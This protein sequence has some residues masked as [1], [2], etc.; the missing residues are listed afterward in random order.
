M[1]NNQPVMKQKQ[2]KQL[3][4]LIGWGIFLI[5]SI[6][7]VLTIEP[8]ASFWDCPEFI[9]SCNKLEVGHPPGAPFFMLTG[10]FFSLFAKDPSQVAYM[11][12]LM[13][14]L[15]SA[16][17][18][19]FLF[20]SITHLAQK[21][22]CPNLNELTVRQAV[23]IFGSGTVGALAYTWS[24]TFWFS[25]VE[26]EVYAYSSLFTALVFWL[27]LKWENDADH[28]HSDRWLIL[29]AYLIGLSIG[30]HLLNLLCIPAIVWVYF[31]KKRPHASW[32]SSTVVLMVSTLLIAV[33]L[34]G[35]VPGIVKMGGYFELLCVNRLGLP[36][37]SGLVTYLVLLAACLIWGIYESYVGKSMPRINLSF[38]LC[39][40]LLG[41]PFCGYG[42][43]SLVAGICITG[44]IA[45]YLFGRI[46]DKWRISIR[47]I[48]TTLIAFMMMII[49]YSSYA[50]IMIRSAA[51]T[52][53]DQNSPE[54]IF[55]LGEYL[56]R[57]QY[58]TRPLF[59]GK[60]YTSRPSIKEVEGGCIYEVT[61][62]APTY[63]PKLKQTPDEKDS[64]EKI[65][66]RQDYVYAQNMLFPRMYSNEHADSYE[67]WLG[68]ME[69]HKVPYNECGDIQMIKVPTQWENLLFLIRYQINFMY[70][71][72]FLWNFAGRQND[73]LG[74]GEIEN[75]N[76]ITGIRFID[77][78]LIGDQTL[79]PDVLKNNKGRN[80]Y[81]CLPLLL[82]IIGLCWQLHNGH[83]GLQQAAIVGI[84]FFMTGLAIVLY[85]NQ[86]P[87]QVRERD[88]AY[89][90]S[91]YAFAIWIGLGVAGIASFLEKKLHMRGTAILTVL[92]CLPVPLQMLGQNWD[93]HD[94]SNRYTCR[95][96]GQNYLNSVTTEGN[97][98]LLSFADND[99]F[100]LWYN[101]EVEGIR[102][103]VRV[104]NLSYLPT[105]WYIDQMRRPAH[106]SPALPIHWTKA[107]YINGKNDVVSIQPDLKPVI[108]KFYREN[109]QEAEEAF[110]KHPFEL[111]HILE[112]WV[113]NPQMGQ[114]VIPTDTAFIPI[115]KEAVRHSGMKMVDSIPD[116]MEIPFKDRRLLSKGDLMVYEILANTNWERP[117]Y[118]NI[119]LSKQLYLNLME[120]FIQEGLSYRISPFKNPKGGP[121]IDSEKMYDNLMHKFHFGGIEQPNIYLEETS[122]RMCDTHRRLFVDLS[123][124]LLNE[125][126]YERALEVLDYCEKV[127]PATNV[128]HDFL[129]GKSKQMA[130][131]YLRLDEVKKA[132]NILK[133]LAE[134]ST[135]FVAWYL[136]LDNNRF[137][138]SYENCVRHIYLLDEICKSWKLTND[139][140][141]G[142][143]SAIAE[144][145]QKQ[146]EELYQMFGQRTKLFK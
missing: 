46:P 120:Y 14:A 68:G 112:Y 95:D 128:P 106:D 51:N 91:F 56:A 27:I 13:N 44:M 41:I 80:V 119:N 25:A 50:L 90:G 97:P 3:N 54:D 108:E 48:N 31:F 87:D 58:G 53:M 64:Y 75:G 17:C 93:D 146:F 15:L 12:N 36:F 19:L 38:L 100:P 33:V 57:E 73:N 127:I 130:D 109:P 122:R 11:I 107:D 117:I 125:G 85:L 23:V 9:L 72:Y 49:G 76:W 8:T 131:N 35:I 134:T 138:Q 143:A 141:T 105:D 55:T 140:K 78:I 142:K 115:D 103:D 96:F 28:A 67:R 118:F 37:N 116:F 32:K 52:P 113:R 21:L 5:A 1:T 101:Q 79:L 92:I 39:I 34:Y 26:G 83:K 47:T 139:P 6:T 86:T 4:N 60:T 10:N 88:Y 124:Q 20:W 121:V 40:L 22:T 129:Y 114:Q 59:Y 63:R 110:G 62:G 94:R 45:F 61:E 2:Y 84:L 102:T 71:R 99:S 70:W 42:V 136:S 29:I 24:D 74:Q 30:V 104:C 137:I 82:G 89:A 66:G 65:P 7:Y 43:S 126:R 77:N 132:E 144:H 98:I 18:I 69:G 81:F 145:Y 111:K 133:Q 16:G 123:S 135:Q